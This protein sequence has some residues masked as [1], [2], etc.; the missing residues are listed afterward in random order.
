MKKYYV[1]NGWGNDW[2]NLYDCYDSHISYENGEEFDNYK[3]ALEYYEDRVQ[4]I[5]GEPKEYV[6]LQEIDDGDYNEILIFEND[7]DGNIIHSCKK[8]GARYKGKVLSVHRY[9]QVTG[10]TSYDVYNK[11]IIAIIVEL[12]DGQRYCFENDRRLNSDWL[13]VVAGDYVSIEK[14]GYVGDDNYDIKI[15]IIKKAGE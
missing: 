7:P 14:N 3:D 10:I 5:K 8:G 6:M 11:T 4:M 1:D 13:I 12:E 9:S 2:N 15:N